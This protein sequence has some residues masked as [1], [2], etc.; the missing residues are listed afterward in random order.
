MFPHSTEGIFESVNIPI[1]QPADVADI[2]DL[3]LAGFALSL[4]DAV[5]PT[6]KT[7]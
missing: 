1:L 5:T 3:S 2:V 6:V 7:V 4:V